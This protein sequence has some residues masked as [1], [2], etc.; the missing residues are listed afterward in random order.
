MGSDKTISIKAQTDPQLDLLII[1]LRKEVEAQRIISELIRNSTPTKLDVFGNI[2]YSLDPVSTETPIEKLY[3]VGIP[4]MRWGQRKNRGSASSGRIPKGSGGKLDKNF[5]GTSKD[6][7]RA[8]ELNRKGKRR[9]SNA[10]LKELTTRMD[11]E[12]KYSKLNPSKLKKGMDIVKTMKAAGDMA[13][14]VYNFTQSPLGKRLLAT[15]KVVN[16]AAAPVRLVS[17]VNRYIPST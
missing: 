14:S 2:D 7:T 17:V 15:K 10:E 4:G 8:R 11:L 13:S 9:L 6:H 5:L 3:H 1:R 16:A 12:A